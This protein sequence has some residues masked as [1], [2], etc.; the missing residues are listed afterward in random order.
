MASKVPVEYA[1]EKID[2]VDAEGAYS[3]HTAELDP[4]AVGKLRRKID[5][6]L[7]PLISIL[8]LCSFL[9]RVNSEFLLPCRVVQKWRSI[10]PP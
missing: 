5:F 3:N 4:V 2:E 6:H 9:D 10:Y 1:S 7:I 8:Y